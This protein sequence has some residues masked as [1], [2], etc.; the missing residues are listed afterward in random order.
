M[1]KSLIIISCIAL[2]LQKGYATRNLKPEKFE[3]KKCAATLPM[4]TVCVVEVWYK[5]GSPSV[6]CCKALEEIDDSCIPSLPPLALF[7]KGLCP[8]NGNDNGRGNGNGLQ[9]PVTSPKVP[10]NASPPNERA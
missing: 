7:I 6:A 3:L 10:N 2:V 4:V 9:F 5:L 8:S 1:L